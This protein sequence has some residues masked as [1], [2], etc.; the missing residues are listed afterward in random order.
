MTNE[1]FEKQKEFILEQQAQFAVGMQQLREAQAQTEIVVARIRKIVA[2]PAN[3]ILKGSSVVKAKINAL[4]DSQKRT[5]EDLKN[6]IAALE[7]YLSER[8]KGN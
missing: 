3:R 1:E 7:R 2:R 5:G 8:R 4:V 6:L